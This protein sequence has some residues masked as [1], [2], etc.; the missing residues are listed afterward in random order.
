MKRAIAKKIKESRRKGDTA[1]SDKDEDKLMQLVRDHY[2]RSTVFLAESAS[3]LKEIAISEI[4][5]F[6]GTLTEHHIHEYILKNWYDEVNW[7]LWG[8]RNPHKIS[9][10][11]T[12]ML[13]EAHW[14]VLKR[15]Y[16]FSFNRPRL[17]LLVHI[18]CS[19]VLRKYLDE[20]K[21]L[22]SGVKKPWWWKEFVKTWKICSN[23]RINGTYVTDKCNFT[24]SCP[25]WARSKFFLCKHLVENEDCPHYGEVNIYRTQPFIC[26]ERGSDRRRA[27]IDNEEL[28]HTGNI[29]NINNVNPNM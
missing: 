27:N 6:F 7:D 12:T 5:N 22:R 15:L 26:L 28:L 20:Y 10:L 2:F 25:A 16:I 8:R 17:D 3:Q 18:I 1:L 11:R 4:N 13:V 9:L 14:S 23:S 19:K 29:S 21:A 24:C